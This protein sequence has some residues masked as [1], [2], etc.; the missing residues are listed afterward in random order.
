MCAGLIEKISEACIKHIDP[1]RNS[2]E[3]WRV[4]YKLINQRL[5]RVARV[6]ES[7]QRCQSDIAVITCFTDETG[8]LLVDDALAGLLS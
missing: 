1:F 3:N 4:F 7:V 8:G 2:H 6:V 5:N